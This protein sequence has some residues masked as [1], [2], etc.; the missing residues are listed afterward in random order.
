MVV[1]RE[2][3]EYAKL[4]AEIEAL[5]QKQTQLDVHLTALSS[6][7]GSHHS[8]LTEASE[9]LAKVCRSRAVHDNVQLSFGCSNSWQLLLPQVPDKSCHSRQRT[10][11][12]FKLHLGLCTGTT[13]MR[14]PAHS[15]SGASNAAEPG[16]L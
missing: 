12:H 13:K 11:P 3:Q 14:S 16:M 7:N 9:Q 5:T 4:E 2:Q 10:A 1:Y 8:E 6:K 15:P